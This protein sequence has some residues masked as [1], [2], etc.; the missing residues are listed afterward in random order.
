MCYSKDSEEVKEALHKLL[1]DVFDHVS[2]GDFDIESY[3]GFFAEGTDDKIIQEQINSLISSVSTDNSRFVRNIKVDDVAI[4]EDDGSIECPK[5]KYAGR[6]RITLTVN[7]PVSY[8][9]SLTFDGSI[10]HRECKKDITCQVKKEDGIM[11]FT[12][13]AKNNS[14]AFLLNYI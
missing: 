12:A 2:E 8:D 5:A 14:L 3:R 6:D 10:N 11:K 13:F 9:D 4:Y 1:Q 7:V